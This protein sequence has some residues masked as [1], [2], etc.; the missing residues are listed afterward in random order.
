MRTALRKNEAGQTMAEYAVL[1]GVLV[2]GV[3]AAIGYFGVA[4]AQYIQSFASAIG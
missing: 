3:V 1:V 2:L 4:V